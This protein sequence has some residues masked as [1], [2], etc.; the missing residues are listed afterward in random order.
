MADSEQPT[1]EPTAAGPTAAPAPTIRSA[2]FTQLDAVPDATSAS[3]IDLILDIA[4]PVAVELG[5]ARMLI[6]DLL[7][8]GPGSVVELD[9]LAGEPVDILVHNKIVAQG[10]VVV[11]D[12]NFGVR[13]TDILD[14][15]QR[16][17][18]LT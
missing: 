11:V 18:S 2:Q 10:E 17:R 8:L 14:P 1:P 9:K 7:A 5:R 6:E 12:E 16:V 4:V 3:K 15:E 13:I